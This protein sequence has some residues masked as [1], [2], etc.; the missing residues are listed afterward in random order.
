M[1][2]PRFYWAISWAPSPAF[3]SEFSSDGTHRRRALRAVSI[4]SPA[5]LSASVSVAAVGGDYR[6]T[7]VECP[8][9]PRRVGELLRDDRARVLVAGVEHQDH[10]EVFG[11]AIERL[12]LGA[13]GIDPLD[14]RVNLHQP[15]AGHPAAFQL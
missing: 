8:G 6:A 15:A 12:E 4:G 9:Q 3:G 14:G 10:A 13:S 11:Q 5:T 2:K 7:L 1:E